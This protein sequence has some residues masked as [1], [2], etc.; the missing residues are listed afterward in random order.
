LNAESYGVTP[1]DCQKYGVKGIN[2][3]Q[4]FYTKCVEVSDK[5]IDSKT[6]YIEPDFFTNFKV[7]NENSEENIFVIV[8]NGNA[9]FDYQE[10]NSMVNKLRITMLTLNYMHE[11]VWG[12]M[13]K[14]WNGFCARPSFIGR[15][16]YGVDRRGPCDS[17]L[18]TKIDFDVEPWGWFIGPVWNA[19]GTDTLVMD[20]KGNLSACMTISVSRLDSASHTDGARLL[21]YQVE[22]NSTLNKFCENDFVLL[23]Y[24]EVLYNKAEASALSLCLSLLFRMIC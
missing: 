16:E 20:D 22:K 21:K 14:P 12:M 17:T 7:Y 2:V 23:R 11:K 3:V 1:E 19:D 13:E 24:A 8:E 6:Y 10:G 4:D 9:K 15:Y 18:G 5:V